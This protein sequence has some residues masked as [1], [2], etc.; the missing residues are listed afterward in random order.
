[1]WHSTPHT[2]RI[3][4]RTLDTIDISARGHRPVSS[5]PAV[6]DRVAVDALQIAEVFSA[7]E[8]DESVNSATLYAEYRRLHGPETH[9]G[10][11]GRAAESTARNNRRRPVSEVNTAAATPLQQ[12]TTPHGLDA[13]TLERWRRR[14]L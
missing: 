2:E 3:D 10:R 5:P 6:L 4:M 1:M 13:D 9:V 14:R 11:A 8:L 7:A 12:Q